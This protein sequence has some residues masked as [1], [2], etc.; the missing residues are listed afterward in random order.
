MKVFWIIERL[1][2]QSH[3]FLTTTVDAFH[4]IGLDIP[5]ANTRVSESSNLLTVLP[6]IGIIT[7]AVWIASTSIWGE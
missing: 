2:E 3:W 6:I 1:P 7:I 4:G 5:E